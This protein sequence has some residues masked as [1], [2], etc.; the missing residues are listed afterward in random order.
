M[1]NKHVFYI[2]C[3]IFIVYFNFSVT[4][5]L[6]KHQKQMFVV[7][8]LFI[9]SFTFSFV[10]EREDLSTITFGLT[11][12]IFKRTLAQVGRRYFAWKN[13]KKYK[14]KELLHM[15]WKE[16]EPVKNSLHEIA[17]FIAGIALVIFGS[18]SLLRRQM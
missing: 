15:S 11:L 8:V 9:L 13:F 7:T 12:I 17:F 3:C 14:K 18:L 2:I 1:E 6:P 16:P 10:L 4:K 5:N